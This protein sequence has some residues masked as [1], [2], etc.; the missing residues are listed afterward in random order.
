M[1]KSKHRRKN[2]TRPRPR[3]VEG[4]IKKPP[5]SP[6]WVPI[7]GVTLLVLGIVIIL[8]GYLP[9]ISTRLQGL[10]GLGNN[11]PLVGGFVLLT[12]GFGFLTQ[13]R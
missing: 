6:A 7:T 3:N 4:P 5:P 12:A 8:L 11:W 9:S 1:P 10:W 2:K 13:W